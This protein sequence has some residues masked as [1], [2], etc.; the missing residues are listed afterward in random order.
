[1][2]ICLDLGHASPYSN[3]SYLSGRLLPNIFENSFD[4]ILLDAPC[5]NENKIFRNKTVQ[6]EWNKEL[7]A[8]MAKAYTPP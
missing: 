6:A 3:S 5:S 8:R 2:R 1:M 4:G 7:V